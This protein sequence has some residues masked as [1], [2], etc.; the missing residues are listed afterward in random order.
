[1]FVSHGRRTE[2]ELFL[3]VLNLVLLL[4]KGGKTLVLVSVAC[5]QA[6]G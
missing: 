5:E 1:M 6:P 2:V 4:T 3:T